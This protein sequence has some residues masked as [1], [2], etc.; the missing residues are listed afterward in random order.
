MDITIDAEDPATADIVALLER[1]LDF[2]RATTD[3]AFVFALD[4]DGLRVPQITFVAA[5]DADGSLLGIGA[6]KRLDDIEGELKSMHTAA[7][8][9]GHGVASAVVADLLARAR[10]AGLRRVS[11]ETGSQDAFTPARALY[12][13][14]GFRECGPFGDYADVPSSAFLTIDL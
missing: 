8:A 3:P 1:H 12:R 2:A 5:R 4:L 11:L 9:R 13:G 6:L 7:E 14:L 10:A